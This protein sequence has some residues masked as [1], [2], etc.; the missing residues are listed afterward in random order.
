MTRASTLRTLASIISAAVLASGPLVFFACSSSRSAF[1]RER[2]LFTED[3]GRAPGG[4]V[5]TRCSSDLKKVLCHREDGTEDTLREC[6]SGEGCGNGACIPACSSAELAMGSTGCAFGA[7]PSDTMT[8]GTAGSCFAV[9]V[10]NTWE[11]PASLKAT[12]G[13]TPIDIGPS[14]YY[15][16]MNGAKIEY[17]RVDGPIAPGKAAIVFLSQDSDPQKLQGN[18]TPCPNGVV[19]A[20]TEDP[21]GHGTTRTRAFFLEMD[22][23]VSAYSIYP[24]GG[25]RS[26]VSTA[27]S[28]LPLSSWGTNYVAVSAWSDRVAQSSSPTLQILASEDDTVV[29]M[30]SNVDISDGNGV[31]GVARGQVQSWKL[32]R[33][34]V[35]QIT[36]PNDPSGSPIEAD[37]PIGLFGGAECPF[38]P[39]TT[40]ACDALQQQIAPTAQW[41]SS[42]ALVPY[43]PRLAKGNA[44]SELRE[45]VPWRFVG[46]VDGTKLTY[47]PSPP[48][49][50]APE[51]LE[52]G[53]TVTFTTTYTGTVRSQDS[54]HP[55]HVTM[56]MT[57]GATSP[58]ELGDPDFV[59]AVAT[60]Q[61]LDRYIFFTDHTYP[62]TTLTFVRRATPGGFA[63]VTLDCMG[64]VSDFRPLGSDGQLEFA[65][66]RLTADGVP[67]SFPGGTC[68]YGR[69]EAR[70]HGPFAV[71]V[72]RTDWFVSY[73]Y[74]GGTGSRP[75]SDVKGPPVK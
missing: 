39:P 55:F 4:C 67:Q 38:V 58:R 12:L 41:G 71:Y 5:S 44:G 54:A 42:Y 11:T 17:T 30:R 13:A 48:P 8:D 16:E 9:I 46:A 61:F 49:F 47:D 52:A 59:T 53:Q 63:P 33:G 7:L 31:P 1:D 35:L 66:V 62:E 45:E 50:G 25:A 2:G 68:G 65:W 22:V 43:R 51:T 57:G 73:G 40:G 74:P 56:F 24:Y 37:K 64:E 69:H 72:W 26:H 27:T 60:D 34:E 20:V 15:A 21:I 10:S 18:F 14:T 6:G 32:A 19:A 75:L 23:P 70:S 29:R 3:D 28:L 36:Q